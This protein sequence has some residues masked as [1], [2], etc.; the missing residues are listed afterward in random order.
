MAGMNYD[1]EFTWKHGVALGAVLINVA[2]YFFLRQFYKYTLALTILVGLLGSITF[3]AIET[4]TA[5]SII[6]MKIQFQPS[7]WW[8]GFLTYIINVKR[9]H[10]FL[11]TVLARKD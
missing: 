10:E 2:C 3:P 9:V 7:A 1:F 6:G 5:I 4:K 8:A 11:F